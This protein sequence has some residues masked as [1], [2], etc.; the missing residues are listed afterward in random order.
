MIRPDLAAIAPYIPGARNDEAVKL[1]SN[2]SSFEPLP[3]VREAMSSAAGTINRYPDFGA[4]DLRQ[5]LAEHLGVSP[6][7]VTVG[8]GSSAL[9]Q[10][11]AIA[12]SQPGQEIIFPWRSF[13]GYPIFTRIAGATPVPIS[14]TAE[15]SLD[16]PAMAAAI[17]EA[18]SLIFVCNPNNPT[19]TTITQAQWEEFIAAVPRRV[20][21]ALDEAYVEYNRS[22]DGPLATTAISSYPNVVGL[23]T[24]SK[25]YGLAGL[26][27]GYAFGAE[28]IISA[29]DKVAVPFGVNS[30]AQAAA[31]A[32]L[33]AT[34]E[35]SERT[36]HTVT[37]RTELSNAIEQSWPGLV[38]AGA[39]GNFIWLAAAQL[40]QILDCTPAELALDLAHRG[41]LVR[42]FAEGVRISLSTVDDSHLVMEALHAFATAHTR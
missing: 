8:T 21:V 18:T 10:Q 6:Q 42:S 32:S 23:R 41:I 24:F 13:E 1:S 29:L 33:R 2:E 15:Q 17:T 31:I 3:A 14:L 22:S 37:A 16:L 7:Q 34:D 38:T 5:E 36:Q 11:L 19:G 12:T 9:C 30:I 26:R 27:V 40:E 20:T 39:Q 25:A 4:E 28:E 35:L